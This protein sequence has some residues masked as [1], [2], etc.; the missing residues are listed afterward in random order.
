LARAYCCRT[1]PATARAYRGM[2]LDTDVNSVQPAGCNSERRV[3]AG[4][5]PTDGGEAVQGEACVDK[6]QQEPAAASCPIFAVPAR[7]QS[8]GVKNRPYRDELPDTATSFPGSLNRTALRR[9]I[10]VWLPNCSG[11]E[12]APAL[13][14][15][16]RCFMTL[17]VPSPI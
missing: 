11:A 10:I 12:V 15:Y 6:E 16:R 5:A 17:A 9:R 1:A 3:A 7:Q 4:S 2:H 8:P 13:Q 14:R